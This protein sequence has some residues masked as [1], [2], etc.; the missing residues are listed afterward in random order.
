MSPN[1]SLL[2]FCLLCLHSVPITAVSWGLP[3][4]WFDDYKTQGCLSEMAL[5]LH[6]LMFPPMPG[7]ADYFLP[8]WL[9]L[10]SFHD[11]PTGNSLFYIQ[12]FHVIH[13]VV[14]ITLRGCTVTSFISCASPWDFLHA[15]SLV[16]SKV[17][18]L[19]SHIIHSIPAS[20]HHGMLHICWTK[21]ETSNSILIFSSLEVSGMGFVGPNPDALSPNQEF[22]E[23]LSLVE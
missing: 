21:W 1:C 9:N 17:L 18:F 5:H 22:S 20:C 6:L 4:L 2:V 10:N 13:K 19:T 12:D 14:L 15:K 23:Y 3:V 7:S 16:T 11:L 8:F